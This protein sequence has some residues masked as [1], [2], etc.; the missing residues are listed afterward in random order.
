MED[1]PL[2]RLEFEHFIA[3]FEAFRDT[4]LDELANLRQTLEI[5]KEDFDDYKK[6]ANR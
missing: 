6:E 2:S 4:M 3:E 1:R 5:Q